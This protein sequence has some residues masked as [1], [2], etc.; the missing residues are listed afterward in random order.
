[1]GEEPS[2]RLVFSPEWKDVKSPTLTISKSVKGAKRTSYSEKPFRRN[3]RARRCVYQATT[4]HKRQ[5][6]CS[7]VSF[8]RC[9]K[10]AGA[11]VIVIFFSIYG[12]W[13]ICYDICE[14]QLPPKVTMGRASESLVF[15]YWKCFLC[16]FLLREFSKT[17]STWSYLR[18]TW[19]T[20]SLILPLPGNVKLVSG[21]FFL[22]WMQNIIVFY[23]LRLRHCLPLGP[24]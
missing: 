8:S 1:M 15:D 18:K 20:I 16:E 23:F 22:V 14:N 11:L 17:V 5:H 4:K 3:K 19:R 6:G 7:G 2:L 24:K 21:I 13:E 9:C 12:C 10:Y